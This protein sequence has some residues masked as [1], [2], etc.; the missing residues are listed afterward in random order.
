MAAV[1]LQ[2]RRAGVKSEALRNVP[3]NVAFCFLLE[4]LL[5]RE[6]SWCYRLRGNMFVFK[7]NLHIQVGH[8]SDRIKIHLF[9]IF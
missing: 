6:G 1:F 3:R 7:K 5:L 2:N 9:L 8:V 4:S